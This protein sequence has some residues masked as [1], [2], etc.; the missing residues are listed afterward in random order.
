MKFVLLLSECECEKFEMALNASNVFFDFDEIDDVFEYT[1]SKRDKHVLMLLI[2][3]Y[4]I[5]VIEF[6]ST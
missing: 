5:N 2:L 3:A 4:D 1:F 6:K